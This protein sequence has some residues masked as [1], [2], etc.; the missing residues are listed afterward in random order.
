ML[1]LLYSGPSW[2]INV[3]FGSQLVGRIRPTEH[4]GIRR[5]NLADHKLLMSVAPL[6]WVRVTTQYELVT[7]LELRNIEPIDKSRAHI[8]YRL[9]VHNAMNEPLPYKSV[10]LT[11]PTQ[12]D[13]I[14]TIQ[15]DDDIT[16]HYIMRSQS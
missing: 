3:K 4:A 6:I 10:T 12:N 13:R 9:S 8:R 5:E 16:L 2:V 7:T 14:R 15:N 11:D 1:L